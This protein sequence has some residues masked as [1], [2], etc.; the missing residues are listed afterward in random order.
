MSLRQI[1]KSDVK[2]HVSRELR[3]SGTPGFLFGSRKIYETTFHLAGHLGV[4]YNTAHII[5]QI[6]PVCILL[7]IYRTLPK[8]R[9][10][11][12]G[13]R[14]ALAFRRAASRRFIVNNN[15]YALTMAVDPQRDPPQAT[16][17]RGDTVP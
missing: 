1:R 11:G 6:R 15:K 17:L 4:C 3:P 13:E 9:T 5:Y 2:G 7:A 12:L 10:Q 14:G 16:M 8:T